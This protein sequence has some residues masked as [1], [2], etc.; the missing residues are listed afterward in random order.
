MSDEEE[1]QESF[2]RAKREIQQAVDEEPALAPYFDRMV[3]ERVFFLNVHRL[4]PVL[5]AVKAL[6]QAE[7]LSVM[8]ES[9][10]GLSPEQLR[11]IAGRS[12]WWTTVLTKVIQAHHQPRLVEVPGRKH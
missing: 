11:A 4:D 2:E 7:E 9:G 12:I 10:D 3:R 6:D 5:V 8:L 1:Y